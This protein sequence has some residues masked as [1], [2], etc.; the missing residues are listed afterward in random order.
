MRVG[1]RLCLPCVALLLVGCA[2]SWCERFNLDCSVE[3]PV[4]VEALG[5]SDGDLWPDDQDC[6]D[7]NAEIHPSAEEICDGLDNDCDGLVDEGF[8]DIRVWYVDE[9][10][11][12]YGA[13]LG[14]YACEQISGM[15]D[16][17]DDCD[18]LENAVRPGANEYC[19]ETD[20]NCDGDPHAGAI[21]G[22]RYFEDGDGDG[23]GGGEGEEACERPEGFLDAGTD[24]VDHDA[25]IH[26][27]AAEL[28]DDLD[29]DCDGDIDE[30][31]AL[32]GVEVHPDDDGDGFGDPEESVL[33]CGPTEGMTLDDS[34]CD[35]DDASINPDAQECR[36]GVDDDCDGLIDEDAIEPDPA[37]RDADGDGYGDPDHHVQLC[38]WTSGYVDN[39]Q[40]CDD[41]EPAVY[42]GATEVCDDLDNDC[43]GFT[44]DADVHLDTSTASLWYTDSDGDGFGDPAETS[45]AC[46]VR[47]GTVAT[48]DDC[49]DADATVYPGAIELCGT[50]VVEDCDLSEAEATARCALEGDVS[51]AWQ[52][53]RV[54]SD[55]LHADLGAGLALA[56][57]VVGDGIDDVLIGAPDNG[58]GQVFLLGGAVSGG[59]SGADALVVFV[60]ETSGDETGSSIA[61]SVD[62]DGDGFLDVIIGAPGHDWGATSGGAA[63]FLA[64]PFSGRHILADEADAIVGNTGSARLGAVVASGGDVT[65]DGYE[66]VVVGAPTGGDSR[67]GA[68]WV[69]SGPLS[70][71]R[72]TGAVSVSLHATSSG[73]DLGTSASF[74][75][76]D[77]D[78]VDDLVVGAPDYPNRGAAFVMFGPVTGE[79][80]PSD[81]VS[82]AG[83]AGNASA[84]MAVAI[85]GDLSGDGID[86][87]VVGDSGY[88]SD[89]SGQGG[90]FVVTGPAS[91]SG[92]L[93]SAWATV[94]GESMYDKLGT[95]LA[96]A[97]DVDEDGL[98]D[99][100]LAA[101][102][103]DGGSTNE[104]AV[105]VMAGLVSGVSSAAD[106]H[107]VLSGGESDSSTGRSL[108]GGLDLDGDDLPDFLVGAPGAGNGG[109]ATLLWRD[110]Y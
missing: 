98:V 105:Y 70:T 79:W 21:N 62:L 14:V 23:Y 15:V 90:A 34:D 99:L 56:G 45:L 73:E 54:E 86:D 44:D 103:V 26:P 8:D 109:A 16:N 28:C 63:W 89:A 29:N 72:Y 37:W 106:A 96:S 71:S 88:T 100:L 93:S 25:Q 6:S 64:G 69:H 31:G 66:D 55:V 87:L 84:G 53:G 104:G 50:G 52:D 46:T 77:G 68:V 24:C 67:G 80:T 108:R 102:G 91:A 35:D 10:N 5:D 47:M 92:N 38:D 9:D 30:P 110:D 75:D 65:G 17:N 2:D 76:L 7:T 59:V 61:D 4:E 48:D 97:G 13:G 107:A 74:G 39:D 12:G 57:D 33:V 58:A 60:G 101:E 42:L 78:G 95:A 51:L 1:G 40:D 43:D 83:A 20:W 36:D 18:D 22:Q 81:V 11:D 41:T 49:D 19:D 32:D 3:Q 27:A 94:L 82:W 85:V